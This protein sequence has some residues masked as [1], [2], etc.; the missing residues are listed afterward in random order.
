MPT[1]F[2]ARIAR[3]TQL[4]LQEETGIT[5][6]VDPVTKEVSF[7]AN[8]LK[9]LNEMEKILTENP[10]PKAVQ[11]SITKLENNEIKNI[12]LQNLEQEKTK[13]V[14]SGLT[15]W[16]RV[17]LSRHPDRPY[18]LKYIQLMCDKFIEL[19]Y[20]LLG[21][22][23]ER[24]DAIDGP[25]DLVFALGEE[26][27][28]VQ[29]GSDKQ[30]RFE[31]IEHLASLMPEDFLTLRLYS[32]QD[33][34]NI[35]WEYAF[36]HLYIESTVIGH[37]DE[38]ETTYYITADDPKIELKAGIVGYASRDAKAKNNPVLRWISNGPGTFAQTSQN[39][40]ELGLFDNT[41]TMPPVK[42]AKTNVLVSLVDHDI[43]AGKT[44]ARFWACRFE[45]DDGNVS[46]VSCLQI[47]DRPKGSG[48]SAP[49]AA[50]GPA[51]PC[52]RACAAPGCGRAY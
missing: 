36:E 14:F 8:D 23:N 20:S 29:I 41:L 40:P 15:P 50:A 49:R 21:P 25:Q 19:R 5:K 51:P 16:Q 42:G 6:V 44:A 35:L 47:R 48:R 13:E 10:L 2:S 43:T 9:G 1:D 52:R 39:S 11:P 22:N 30:I 38:T 12:P 4:V 46:H 28:K 31:N 33:A 45:G 18:T 26:E 24:L 7:K 34:G 3:N 27:I 17:Q 37:N 32:N